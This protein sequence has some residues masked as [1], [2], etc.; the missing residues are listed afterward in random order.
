MGRC[1]GASAE[2]CRDNGCVDTLMSQT[3][4]AALIRHGD[5][6]SRYAVNKLVY[7]FVTSHTV[8]WGRAMSFSAWTSPRG[9]NLSKPAGMPAS[10]PESTSMR[11]G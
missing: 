5:V 1:E 6:P 10:P 2:D 7:C 9:S 11:P 8:S 3:S 4:I